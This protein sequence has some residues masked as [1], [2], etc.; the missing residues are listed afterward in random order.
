MILPLYPVQYLLG[1]PLL[2]AMYDDV[3]FRQ[4]HDAAILRHEIVVHEGAGVSGRKGPA[5]GKESD[6]EGD[7]GKD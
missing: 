2:E 6:C 3:P 5:G 7:D 4:W 1:D